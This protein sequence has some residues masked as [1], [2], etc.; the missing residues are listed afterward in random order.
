MVS[1]NTNTQARSDKIQSNVKNKAFL[2]CA[3]TEDK[4]S[5]FFFHV[6][7]EFKKSMCDK[8]K[9]LDVWKMYCL[10]K[11][12]SVASSVSSHL[13]IAISVKSL[14]S[15]GEGDKWAYFVESMSWPTKTTSFTMISLISTTWK[16]TNIYD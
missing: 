8:D 2:K 5:I 15:L 16:T 4:S 3:K 13:L 9:R 6:M 12:Y 7:L 11:K 10:W 14:S 1:K